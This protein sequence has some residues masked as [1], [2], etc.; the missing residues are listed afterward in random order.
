[1]LVV[2]YVTLSMMVLRDQATRWIGIIVLALSFILLTATSNDVVGKAMSDWA[3][4]HSFLV[5]GALSLYIYIAVIV[6]NPAT[7][8]DAKPYVAPWPKE[9]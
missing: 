5:L 3:Y 7:L 2:P 6:W 1:V 8:R 4:F 9:P